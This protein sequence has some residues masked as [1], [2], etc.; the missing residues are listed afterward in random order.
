MMPVD[1][2]Q[3]LT[4]TAAISQERITHKGL[5]LN[6]NL[7]D[8]ISHFVISD[9]TR[10]RQV[11]INLI[12]N[13]IKFTDAGEI[14]I[15]AMPLEASKVRFEVI[16]T[17][18][19]MTEK[20]QSRLFKPFSQADESI[21]R[22]YGGTG[23]GLMLCKEIVEA[24]GGSIG[25]TSEVG[26]GSCFWFELPLE[27]TDDIEPATPLIATNELTISEDRPKDFSQLLVDKRLL[28]VEDNPVNQMVASKLLQK[29]GTVPDIANNGQ[30]ALDKLKVT[31]YDLVLLDLEMPVMDGYTTIAHIRTEENYSDV[32]RHQL[33]IVMSANALNED[34]QRVLA[35]GVDDYITKPINF[36][37]LKATLEKWIV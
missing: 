31:S 16:D 19:G 22:R 2:P 33:V 17:G 18:I 14:T 1:L 10:L 5:A 30:E 13:A 36:L 35:L 11:L 4:D 37:A 7:N 24:L 23:L 8:A 12:G 28:L 3:L 9:P 32:Y 20:A 27:P 25:V 21:T 6:I 26:K 29:L 34:K 15:N